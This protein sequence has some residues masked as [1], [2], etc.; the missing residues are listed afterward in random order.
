MS[1][2]R[3]SPREPATA[4]LAFVIV[5]SAIWAWSGRAASASAGTVVAP[6]TVRSGG[7][8]GAGEHPFVDVRVGNG[9]TVPVLL[10]T[11]WVGLHLYAD[12]VRTG[13][14]RGVAVTTQVNSITYIDGT[15]QRGLVARAT[16]TIA[17]IATRT[18]MAFGL[19][20]AVGCTTAPPDCPTKGGLAGVERKGLYGTL[21]IGLGPG[22]IDNPLVHLPAP[23]SSS[24][25]ISLA[26]AAGRLILGAHAAASPSDRFALP[27]DGKHQNGTVAF[28]DKRASVCWTLGSRVTTCD[29]TLFDSGDSATHFFGGVP[30]GAPASASGALLPGTSVAASQPGVV[31]PFWSFHV[32]PTTPP[33][34]VHAAKSGDGSVNT[35]VQ[36]FYA[37]RIVFNA[38]RGVISLTRTS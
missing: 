9:R 38:L 18:P 30:G 21:G 16:V 19:I 2:W 11:G 14:G 7:A 23:Y 34:A 28:A 27:R 25:S 5:L 3:S 32:G 36:A 24:W 37:F 12:A 6:I 17:G 31:T 4:V 8:A 13:S 20:N 26:G 15:T 29:P 1:F 10:D 22:P 33:D 35:G